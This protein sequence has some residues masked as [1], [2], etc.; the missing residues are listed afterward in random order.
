MNFEELRNKHEREISSWSNG[1]IFWI[2][3]SSE[4]EFLNKLDELNLKPDD[5][6]AIGAGGYI[7]KEYTSEFHEIINRHFDEKKEYTLNNIYE[8]VK[9][10][11]WD[12]EME[13]SISMT[14]KELLEDFLD[15]SQE[16]IKQ[17]AAEINRAIDDYKKEFYE[18]N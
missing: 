11:L 4:T 16:Q 7:L 8:V 2:F 18:C 17:N 15:L 13:I 6:R 12:F 10:Y 3:A 9:Y 14:L 1:K 5:L